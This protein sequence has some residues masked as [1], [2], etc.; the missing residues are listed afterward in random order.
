MDNIKHKYIIDSPEICVHGFLRFNLLMKGELIE[1]IESET[2]FTHKMIEKKGES[3]E[4]FKLFPII[5]RVDSTSS[6]HYSHCYALLIESICDISPPMRSEYLRVIVSELNRIS[7]HLYWIGRYLKN[8][9]ENSYSFFAFEDREMILDIFKEL[10][11]SRFPHSYIIPGGVRTDFNKNLTGKISIVSK[12][13]KKRLYLLQSIILQSTLF[14]SRTKNVGIIDNKCA[15]AF[16]LSGIAMRSTGIDYDIRRSKPYSIYDNIEFNTPTGN[17]GDSL[18]RFQ[19]RVSEID[20]SLS[21][22]SQSLELLPQTAFNE[23]VDF[24]KNL[25]EGIYTQSVETAR[26]E[27][28]MF[29]SCDGTNIPTRFKIK[30]PS[31]SNLYLLNDISKG[32]NISEF[33]ASTGSFDIM[34]SEIDR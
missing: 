11:G 25:K 15:R 18:D 13:I 20:E 23:D 31:F 7:S 1:S 10:T 19:I 5:E 33:I 14:I 4:W 16:G 17:N 21:I 8:L 32:M 29:L 24:L 27:L 6:L 26:G 28:T 30:T 3:C 34:V 12:K 2:G 9:G 22:I